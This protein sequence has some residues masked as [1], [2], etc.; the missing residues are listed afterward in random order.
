MIRFLRLIYSKA[1][2]LF[3]PNI[4]KPQVNSFEDMDQRWTDPI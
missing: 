3:F 4:Q 2:S 1:R